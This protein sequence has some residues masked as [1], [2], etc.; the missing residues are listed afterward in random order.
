MA[1][2]YRYAFAKKKETRKGKLS[3]GLAVAS[4]LLFLTAVLLAFVLQG[5]LGFLVGGVSLFA[6]LL[7]F[8]GFAM[9]LSGFSEENCKHRTSTIGSIANGCI[10]VGWIC[11]FL[12]GI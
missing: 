6:T 3:V 7:S 5:K 9:G 10:A 1:K 8:Y 12:M 2:R 11:L 4:F